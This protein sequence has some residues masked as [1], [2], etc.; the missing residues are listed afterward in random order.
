MPRPRE[1]G[2]PFRFFN[3]SPDVIRFAVLLYF[4]FP[5]SLRNVEGLMFKRGIDVCHEAV[6]LWWNRI[7][8]MFAADT[9]RQRVNRMPGFR[10]LQAPIA[11]VSGETSSSNERT[12]RLKG[13]D[14]PKPR[15]PSSTKAPTVALKAWV[16]AETYL[17]Q[18]SA[19]S[20]AAS[21][22]LTSRALGETRPEIEPQSLGIVRDTIV[23]LSSLIELL[24]NSLDR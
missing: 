15:K 10:L 4:R 21:C 23:A 19:T 16:Q 8:P 7:G 6:R 9:R 24:D 14:T 20:Y 3:S 1:P 13:I 12:S 5:L 18:R 11:L 17:K 22:I 2:S